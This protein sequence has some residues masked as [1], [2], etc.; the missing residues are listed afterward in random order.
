LVGDPGVGKSFLIKNLAKNIANGGFSFPSLDK[1]I[2]K[3]DTLNLSSGVKQRIEIEN[4]FKG[5][6]EEIVQSKQ[7]ILLIDDIHSLLNIDGVH[8]PN[9]LSNFFS[10]YDFQC[11]VTTN[12]EDYYK[13]FENTN[14][15]L[16]SKF[17]MV[18]IEPATIEETEKIIN[19]IKNLYEN[20]YSISFSDEIIKKCIS[21]TDKYLVNKKFP[22]KAIEFLDE[23][24]AYILIKNDNL[25]P[26]MQDYFS[27]ISDAK[28]KQ[29]ENAMA[30]DFK[31]AI[32][33]RDSVQ[34]Y[35]TQLNFLKEKNR[36]VKK[37]NKKIEVTES[38]VVNVIS[39]C[40]G[41]SVE[42]ILQSGHKDQDNIIKNLKQQ[43]FGQDEAIQT[44]TK[45]IFKNYCGFSNHNHPI[46]VFLFLGPTGVGKTELAKLLSLYLF[47]G[48][49]AFIQ[50]NMNEY[51]ERHDIYKLIGS[52]PGYVGY[53]DG[54]FLLK[55][56]KKY[57]HCLILF[58]EIEKANKEIHKILLQIMDAGKTIDVNG[59]V[60]D[61]RNTVIIMTSNIGF[62][63]EDMRKIGFENDSFNSQ[64]EKNL[65]SELL[66]YFS[67]EFINRIDEIISFKTIDAD[68]VKVIVD[69]K[70]KDLQ[71]GLKKI[72]YEIKFG[73]Q[74][75]DF[76]YKK[77]YN[78]MYGARYVQ[79]TVSK[80]LEIFLYNKIAEHELVK[81]EKVLIDMLEDKLF[82]KKICYE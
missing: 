77:S 37:S 22:R 10:N 45:S 26:K 20:Y 55:K 51:L 52:P 5:L 57:N 25:T 60:V 75:K 19:S 66:K 18:K 6:L 23:I 3:L 81:N 64:I 47:K 24:G 69:A 78:P 11:I 7:V 34:L 48:G 72:N 40:T 39:N 49:E 30:L 28:V 16:A 76:L 74:L 70:L 63:L 29:I 32:E 38:D 33:Y 50:I 82:F 43:I 59:N 44:V 54:G 27:Q 15:N 61:F 21:L 46:G 79:R 80:Y 42:R 58:D 14:K 62:N 67:L 53:Q 13:Y 41:I 36:K 1:K 4:R 73:K 65:N 17:E 9:I 12:F 71:E 35:S 56:V 2:F 8:L 31:K 68:T